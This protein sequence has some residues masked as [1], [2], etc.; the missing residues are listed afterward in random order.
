MV[1]PLQSALSQGKP[2]P[3]LQHN[4]STYTSLDR[5]R[6][7]AGSALHC[8]LQTGFRS[9]Q[10]KHII[11]VVIVIINQVLLILIN[12]DNNNTNT[13]KPRQLAWSLSDSNTPEIAVIF[14]LIKSSSAKILL[15][16]AMIKYTIT[17]S[18]QD[19]DKFSLN[20]L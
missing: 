20:T 1:L 14:L 5:S 13:N 8:A 15:F 19:K 10:N 4:N 17:Q 11:F 12:N 3:L 2:Q 16:P 7:S 18:K 6:L 9:W